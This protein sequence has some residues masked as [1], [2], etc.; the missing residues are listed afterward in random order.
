MVFR[1]GLTFTETGGELHIAQARPVG[2]EYLF[3]NPGSSDV[4]IFDALVDDPQINLIEGLH[5]GVVISM[6]DGYHK[7]SQKPAFVN[8]NDIAGTAQMAGQL[9]NCSK[10]GL[11][12]VVTAGLNGNEVFKRRGWS[13]EVLLYQSNLDQSASARESARAPKMTSS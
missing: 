2:V 1:L 7:V 11:A 3:T 8:V 10:G 6:A 9:F 5:E 12:I 13:S 4:A